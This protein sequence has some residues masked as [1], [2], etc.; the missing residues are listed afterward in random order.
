MFSLA[1][2][3]MACR[4]Q[5]KPKNEDSLRVGN[6]IGMQKDSIVAPEI[7]ENSKEPDLILR[8]LDTSINSRLI[9]WN[10]ESVIN[11][12]GNLDGKL[13]DYDT[14]S[15]D[16]YFKNGKGEQYLQ[17][18]QLPG[19]SSNTITYFEV[20][21]VNDLKSRIKLYL[22]SV[23]AFITGKGISLGVSR[24]YVID[25]MGH[26]YMTGKDE[27]DDFISYNHEVDGLYYTATY[28]FRKGKLVRFGF[29]YDNP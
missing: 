3:L 27:V 25:A 22:S 8:L 9:L 20:G 4:H 5:G 7:P 18:I 15:S 17:M 1:I 6:A 2:T 16:V 14:A 26:D 11:Y 29:G 10:P 12:L 28:F 13:N 19:S 24:D 23:A 21:F